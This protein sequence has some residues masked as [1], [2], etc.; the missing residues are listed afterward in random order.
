V[1]FAKV[2]MAREVLHRDYVTDEDIWML[3]RAGKFDGLASDAGAA[4]PRP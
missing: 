2:K 3:E 4:A 1:L